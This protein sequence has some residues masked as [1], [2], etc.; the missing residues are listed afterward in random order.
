MFRAHSR[1]KVSVMDYD[2][3]W[4]IPSDSLQTFVEAD[5]YWSDLARSIQTGKEADSYWSVLADSLH[6]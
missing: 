5:F 4:S 3:H 1:Q 2:P 6:I